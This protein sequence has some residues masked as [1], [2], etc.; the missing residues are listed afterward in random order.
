MRKRIGLSVGT[1]LLLGLGGIAWSSVGG[2]ST[3][4]GVTSVAT[5][6][7]QLQGNPKNTSSWHAGIA[8]SPLPGWYR[9]EVAA[10]TAPSCWYSGEKG[11]VQWRVWADSAGTT[12]FIHVLGSGVRT[13]FKCA[14]GYKA[15]TMFVTLAST[16]MRG[17][18]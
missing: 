14:N 15:G 16:T 13:T 2:A 18:P 9:Y 11:A 4:M 6:A 12:G 8:I 1:V 17:T 10:T 5:Y 3:S 7:T